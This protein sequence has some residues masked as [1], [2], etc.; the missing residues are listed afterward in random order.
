M[1]VKTLI[2]VLLAV[3]LVVTACSDS[4]SRRAKPAP[5]KAEKAAKKRGQIQKVALPPVDPNYRYDP[6]GKPDPFRSFVKTFLT[7]RKDESATTPL[8]RFDLSQLR[9][10]AII[11]GNPAPKALIEDPSGKGYIVGSGTA[12][13]KNKG[14]IIRIDD[15]LVLVKETYVDFS[16]KSSSKDIEMR[17]NRSQ[18]G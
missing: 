15:N 16:G 13:G 9:V 8:E 12:I 17:M 6:K 2:V 1:R 18:G 10:T 14:R 4:G 3:G 7:R 11:W 5:A